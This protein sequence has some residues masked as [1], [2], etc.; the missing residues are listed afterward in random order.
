MFI[1]LDF[2]IEM[3]IGLYVSLGF[4]TN[5]YRINIKV[6]KLARDHPEVLNQYYKH[7]TFFEQDKELSKAI[8]QLN[9]KDP[10]NKRSV[11]ELI[12]LKVSSLKY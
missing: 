7:Q 11:A 10:E 9:L 2:F 3:L 6:E 8:L 4:G 5:E 12:H 1:L